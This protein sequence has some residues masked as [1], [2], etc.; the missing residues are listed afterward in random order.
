M[1]L[2][3]CLLM[4]TS[5]EFGCHIYA[6]TYTLSLTPLV[7]YQ[8]QVNWYSR[9]AQSKCSAYLF[10]QGNMSDLNACIYICLIWIMH[11]HILASSLSSVEL[12]AGPLGTHYLQWFSQGLDVTLPELLLYLPRKTV[13]LFPDTYSSIQTR[14]FNCLIA[15]SIFPTEPT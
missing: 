5:G 7:Q 8:I 4:S 13:I 10:N 6:H 14:L 9:S 3:F 12:W 15:A 11:E 2:P 1:A